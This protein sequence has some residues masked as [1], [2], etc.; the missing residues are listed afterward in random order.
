MMIQA[1]FEDS[2]KSKGTNIS[3]IPFK[4][5]VAVICFPCTWVTKRPP[6]KV[7]AKLGSSPGKSGKC[8]NRRNGPYDQDLGLYICI[9]SV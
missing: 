5:M 4:F 3:I 6:V 8:W 1:S 2:E 7:R 9:P